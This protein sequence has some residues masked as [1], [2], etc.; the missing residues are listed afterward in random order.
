MRSKWLHALEQGAQIIC[1]RHLINDCS[2]PQDLIVSGSKWDL[3][4]NET[5]TDW[6][7]PEHVDCNRRAGGKNGA[8]KTNAKIKTIDRDA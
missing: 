3:G 7:G 2:H 5:R 8:K 4:H 1:A 6:T